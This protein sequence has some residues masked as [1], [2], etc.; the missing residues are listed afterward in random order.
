MVVIFCFCSNSGK[1]GEL[2]RINF[3]KKISTSLDLEFLVFA[4]EKI[5]DLISFILICFISFNFIS[6]FNFKFLIYLIIFLF[7]ILI[8]Y[9]N[10]IILKKFL[11][12]VFSKIDN[13]NFGGLY[14]SF[15]KVAKL[16]I[17]IISL[18]IGSFAWF[19]EC[20]GVYKLLYNLNEYDLSIVKACFTHT[21]STLVGLITLIPGGIATT[22]LTSSKLLLNFGL[23]VDNAIIYSFLLRFVSIWYGT[24]LGFLVFFIRLIKKK[25]I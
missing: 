12:L 4:I 15:T 25:K 21:A 17:F 5:S 23:Q 8:I 20:L 16:K 19:I 7:F 3:Y 22:E 13:K 10:K 2:I 1:I 18:S 6:N 11:K 14:E 24:I 9:K